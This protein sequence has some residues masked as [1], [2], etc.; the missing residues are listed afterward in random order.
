[1]PLVAILFIAGCGQYEGNVEKLNF[2]F[3]TYNHFPSSLDDAER[4]F[5]GGRT[6]KI[7]TRSL[8]D[9]M[10]KTAKNFIDLVENSVEYP[11]LL[12]F[13]AVLSWFYMHIFIKAFGVNL[14]M[15]APLSIFPLF[16]LGS[17]IDR[18]GS[19]TVTNI[20]IVSLVMIKMGV[21]NVHVAHFSSK[22]LLWWGKLLFLIGPAGAVIIRTLRKVLTLQGY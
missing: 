21:I 3:Q 15:L 13:V 17:D 6:A 1:M 14:L 18:W 11:T 12:F 19:L 4:K 22:R 9:N 2:K 8:A 5:R 7:W 10:V 16:L 20:F